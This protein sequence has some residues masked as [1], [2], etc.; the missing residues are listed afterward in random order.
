[1][2][3]DMDVPEDAA[4]LARRL[5]EDMKGSSRSRPVSGSAR[6]TIAKLAND[7]AKADPDL[8]G[9]C[10]LRDERTRQRLYERTPADAVWGIG[11]RTAEKLAALGVDT[12]ACLTALLAR[13]VRDTL[14]VVGT[15]VQAELCGV[16]ACRCR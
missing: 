8:E 1:M 14:T 5:R 6:K 9:I 15:R 13:S 2:F 11:P 12:I 3:L 7:A 10:D 4:I 16:P